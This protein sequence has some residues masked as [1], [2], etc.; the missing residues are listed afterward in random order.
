MNIVTT[1]KEIVTFFEMTASNSLSYN[2][3]NTGLLLGDETARVK[4]VLLALDITPR[5]VNY[6]IDSGSDLIISHH[7]L[8]ISPKKR[9]TDPYLLNLI[10]K[11]ISV[12]CLHTNLD[13]I[14]GGVSHA[15][16]SMLDIQVS[17][18][19]APLNDQ[20][21]YHI[22]VYVPV[23]FRDEFSQGV[24]EAGAG[25]IGNYD[26]CITSHRV[27]GQFRPL[28]GS[29]PLIGKLE[30]IE[31]V[32]EIKCEFFVEASILTRVIEKILA[33]HPYDTPVYAVYPLEQKSSNYGLGVVGEI[34]PGVTLEQ[35]AQ[36]VKENLKAPYVKLWLA[37]KTPETVVSKIAVCGGSGSSVLADAERKADVF[38]S[39]D[40]TYHRFLESKIPLIDAGHFYTEFPI[41]KTLKK[42]LQAF[43]LEIELFP[44]EKADINKLI[45]I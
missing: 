16:A 42:Q 22:A 6:A 26:H 7:P 43:N 23:E 24:S 28:K 33:I 10:K 41:L 44:L 12:L 9:I 39:S 36:R 21:V 40:F 5:V 35:M 18:F 3:D 4:K 45:I 25:V 17:G 11:N 20:K 15:L 13:V 14:K 34:S 32:E 37:N 1:V 29:N 19:L 38:V 2:W 27:Q 8:F 30:R 31:Q